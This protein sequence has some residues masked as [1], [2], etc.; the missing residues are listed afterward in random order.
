M[1]V[2]ADVSGE[3]RKAADVLAEARMHHMNEIPRKSSISSGG[4]SDRR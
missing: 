3:G 1:P 2:L 4:T